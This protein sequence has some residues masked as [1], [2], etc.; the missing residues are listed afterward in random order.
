MLIDI[1]S[2]KEITYVP[3]PQTFN[4]L[5]TCLSPKEFDDIVVH[6]NELIENAGGE[7]VTAGWLPGS[8]WSEYS[9]P[10]HLRD[11][12]QEEPR[13]SWQDVRSH[14]LVYGNETTRALGFWSIREGRSRNREH[15]LLP[16]RVI[17]WVAQAGV[18]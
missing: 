6:I 7:I 4:P 2:G 17:S 15:D 3:H 14:G 11:H 18:A 13:F 12:S 1:E 16:P 9:F 8:D 10:A 5:Q